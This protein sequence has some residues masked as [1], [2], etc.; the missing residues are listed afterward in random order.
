MCE[1]EKLII[2]IKSEQPPARILSACCVQGCLTHDVRKRIVAWGISFTSEV[3][4]VLVIYP[5]CV[6]IGL[7]LRL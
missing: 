7:D 2:G 6:S 3:V 5:L 1:L 4:R